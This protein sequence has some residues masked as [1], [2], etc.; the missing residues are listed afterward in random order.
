MGIL[1]ARENMAVT[2]HSPSRVALGFSPACAALK[3]RATSSAAGNHPRRERRGWLNK[4]PA[5]AA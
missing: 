2:G 1:P 3:G 5:D 4:K